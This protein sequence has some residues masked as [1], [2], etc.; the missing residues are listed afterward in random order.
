MYAHAH[1]CVYICLV[2]IRLL[3]VI[4]AKQVCLGYCSTEDGFIKSSLH[5]VNWG[6]NLKNDIWFIELQS[7]MYAY[8]VLSML[9]HTS[10]SM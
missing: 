6:R 1:R 9:T 8:S 4:A 2:S 5:W 3:I 7:S 10:Q